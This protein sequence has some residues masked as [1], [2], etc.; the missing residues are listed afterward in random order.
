MHGSHSC[1]CCKF[2]KLERKTV[3]VSPASAITLVCMHKWGFND[4]ENN[5]VK[6]E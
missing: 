2:K 4:A 1:N 3:P 5:T 6:T